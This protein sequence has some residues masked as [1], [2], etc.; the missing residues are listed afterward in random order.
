MKI[1]KSRLLRLIQEG[2]NSLSLNLN[3]N[4]SILNTVQITALHKNTKYRT[5]Y[6]HDGWQ[7]QHESICSQNLSPSSCMLLVKKDAKVHI[8]LHIKVSV[9]L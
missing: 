2:K 6:D 8:K 9:I 7:H 5:N 1:Q 3:A 4:Y